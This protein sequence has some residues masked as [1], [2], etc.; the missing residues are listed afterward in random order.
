MQVYGNSLGLSEL[1][2]CMIALTQL[3]DGMAE[4]GGGMEVSECKD[5]SVNEMENYCMRELKR[6]RRDLVIG[7]VLFGAIGMILLTVLTIY[8]T[9]TGVNKR[10]TLFGFIVMWIIFLSALVL[11]IRK[12][13]LTIQNV[14]NASL[15]KS[16]RKQLPNQECNGEIEH[17]FS[18]LDAN[19]AKTQ[20][21]IGRF[22]LGSEWMMGGLRVD[23]LQL[24]MKILSGTVGA[25]SIKQIIAG[26]A[27]RKDIYTYYAWEKTSSSLIEEAIR[28]FGIYRR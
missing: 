1:L 5:I 21:S 22:C 16:I 2:Q 19:F 17:I 7:T 26:I 6:E 18:I 28:F 20:C 8:T 23:R 4:N 3:I 12:C 14:E 27:V 10:T 11:F 25:G 9:N 13:Y 15:V 24:N